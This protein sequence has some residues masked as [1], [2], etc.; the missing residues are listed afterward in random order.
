MI[1]KRRLYIRGDPDLTGCYLGTRLEL[2]VKTIGGSPTSLQ[3]KR[4]D[5]WQKLG[6][7]S[8]VVWSLSDVIKAMDSILLSKDKKLLA[9]MIED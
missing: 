7:V 2:E 5:D 1:R 4:I 9:N 8:A 6:C 3:L